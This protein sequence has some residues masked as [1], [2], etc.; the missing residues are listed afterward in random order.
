PLPPSPPEEADVVVDAELL[1]PEDTDVVDAESPPPDA[2]S[3]AVPSHPSTI[4]AGSAR[5]R[6]PRVHRGPINN[7]VVTS[8][9]IVFSE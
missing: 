1:L 3:P 2:E 6:R 9:L 8:W 7:P 4:M 5:C